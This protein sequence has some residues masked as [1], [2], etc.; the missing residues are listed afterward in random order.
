MTDVF[1][2]TL[3]PDDAK[4][5][6][7]R[8]LLEE[9]GVTHINETHKGELIHSCP[10]PLG[11]HSNGDR[12]PS[13]SLNYKKLTFKCLGCGHSG[14]LIWFA[15]TCRGED[16]QQVRA[17]IEG[18]TGL[19]QTV[20][21]LPKLLDLLDAYAKPGTVARTPMPNYDPSVLK[22][23]T[24][25]IQHPILTD[26]MPEIGIK[27]RGLREDTLNHFRVC[28]AEEYPMG[29]DAATQE[30]IVIPHFWK[31]QLVGWQA[32]RIDG[33]DEPKYKNSPDFP[34]DTTLYNF[35]PKCRQIV[36]VESPMSVLARWHHVPEMMATF[37]AT[38]TEDQ[39]KLLQRFD[40]VITWFDNDKAGWRATRQ[41]QNELSRFTTVLVV[42]NPYD[43]DAA[44]VDDTTADRLIAEAIPP[45]VWNPPRRLEPLNA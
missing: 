3:L 42:D 1:E 23:W 15:A 31:G 35:D 17:W 24:W 20:M 12:K 39:L 45:V 4:R 14:G 34:K 36:V 7:C 41:V 27:G 22:P 18:E 40:R 28:Y 8:A 43:A 33:R 11:G 21:D 10:L 32:R 38:L 29:K 16:S 19:G 25:P 6:L 30:R 5:D 37:G 44:D 26:G 9:F 2:P 13:A